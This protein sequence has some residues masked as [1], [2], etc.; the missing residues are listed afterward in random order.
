M[1]EHQVRLEEH[2]HLPI[3]DF[4]PLAWGKELGWQ[5]RTAPEFHIFYDL[6]LAGWV[7][8]RVGDARR[9]AAVYP[10]RWCDVLALH[11]G[12]CNACVA[13]QPHD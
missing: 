11:L 8:R 7:V 4:K 13:G 1:P 2:Y 9:A 10:A 12:A 5:S 6:E 3:S